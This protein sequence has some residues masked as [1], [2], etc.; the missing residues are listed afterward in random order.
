MKHYYYQIMKNFYQYFIKHIIVLSFVGFLSSLNI[1]SSDTT[2]VSLDLN[3]VLTSIELKFFSP[4]ITEKHSSIENLEKIISELKN[5]INQD[6]SPKHIILARAL[7]L[8]SL[9][10][11]SHHT[12]NDIFQ[13]L[14]LE[15]NISSF[16]N[17]IQ[18]NSALMTE[19]IDT[20]NTLL[21][22]LYITQARYSLASHEAAHALTLLQLAL[23]FN[24][25]TPAFI[26]YEMA[27]VHNKY[28]NSVLETSPSE[29]LKRLL[30]PASN[31]DS[32]QKTLIYLMLADLLPQQT[33][34]YLIQ[35]SNSWQTA[36]EEKYS[37]D[38][39][40]DYLHQHLPQTLTTNIQ[41]LFSMISN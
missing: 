2:T 20:W 10:A 15:E 16:A 32:L 34:S 13:A 38:I 24:N 9:I 37:E 4:S 33:E 36:L 28:S 3:T 23:S 29:E 26:L 40:N 21:T 41:Q 18:F 5:I 17:T 35:A 14:L 7:Y 19:E 39:F 22:S 12:I 30:E 6:I 31:R 11:P 8:R 25:D 1:F 27:Y